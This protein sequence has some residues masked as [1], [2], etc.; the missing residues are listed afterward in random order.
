MRSWE[1]A[2]SL[3]SVL[4]V[5]SGSKLPWNS[6][7]IIKAHR[8]SIE[9]YRKIHLF[10]YA[11]STARYHESN[12]VQAGEHIQSVSIGALR[13]GLSIC[14]DLR[15]PE[16]YRHLAL[17][18]GAQILLVPSAFTRETGE[19]HWHTLLR[20]RAIENLSFVAAAAQWGSHRNSQGQ[21]L[22]CYGHSL[23]V[24]P[25]GRVLAEAPGQGDALLVVDLELDELR[26]SRERL[27]SLSSVRLMRIK[28]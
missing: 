8:S 17:L 2:V 4:E 25:W 27:P 15:F 20:S 3:G 18:Q 10:D 26:R 1:I 5:G 23:V 7:W 9:A 6:H 12:D 28:S 19:A 22:F 14:Y 11:G 16:L 13:A 24:D 21:E